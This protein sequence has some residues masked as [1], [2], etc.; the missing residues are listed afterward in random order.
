MTRPLGYLSVVAGLVAVCLLMGSPV[1]QGAWA[2]SEAPMLTELVRSGA[3]PPVEKRLPESPVMVKPFEKPGTYGGTWRRAYTG[4]SDLVGAR[5]VLYDPLVRW[6]PD[7]KIIPNLAHRWEASEDGR[8]FT[9]HLVKGVKWSDGAPF[10][11]DDILFYYEDVLLNK[12]LTASLPRWIAPTGK[13]PVVTKIDDF[14][15]RFEFDAPYSLFLERLACPDAMALVTKPKH[16]LKRFHAKYA[17]PKELEALLQERKVSSW[18]RLFL[19]VSDVKHAQFTEKHLPSICA[20]ITKVPAP[21]KRFVM[22]RNPYYW[23]VDTAGNQLPYIDTV[24]HELQAEAQT[25]VLKAVAGEI[26][27]QGRRLGGM[28]NSV[29]LKSALKKGTYRLVPKVSTASVG[30]LLAPNLNHQDPVT[31]AVLND[32]RFRKA[33]SYAINRSEIN[34]TFYA[35]Q[36]HPRQAAPLKESPFYSASYEKA[37]IDYDPAKANALLDEMGLKKNSSGKRLRPDGEPLRLSLDV[38]VDVQLHVDTAEILASNLKAIGIDT[39]VKSEARE[40]FRQRTLTAAHDI[41]LWGGDG[42]MEC[43]LDP[44]WYFPYS[45]ESLHAP[46]FG[47]W[48]QS[49]GTKGTEPPEEI[50]TL[51]KIYDQILTSVS[52]EKKKELF[53]KIIEANEKNLWVIGLVYDPPDYYVVSKKMHNVAERDFQSWMY[54][55]PGPIYPEQFFFESGQ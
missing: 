16:Y 15:I 22:E 5:R 31:R 48:Y 30:L 35:G 9:F 17:D 51:C 7:Y 4:L 19:D 49:G 3:L 38:T 32:A 53:G 12:E 13:P 44:R 50:K 24:V 54:P 2:Y 40:L 37:Y 41:A 6:S 26:D 43:L 34:K 42:G 36:G 39:E 52:D 28:Q 10:T 33:I 8:V 45:T 11:A 47:L 14:T 20:W 1:G 46:L 55:N 18:A 21:A 25:I 23:K 29:L 27:M